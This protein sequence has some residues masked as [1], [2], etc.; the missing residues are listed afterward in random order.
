[1]TFTSTQKEIIDV[2]LKLVDKNKQHPKREDMAKEGYSNNKIRRHFTSL[3]NLRLIVKKEHP[4]KFEDVVDSSL[5]TR[6]KF[7]E[8][9]GEVSKYK[10]FVIT[11]AVND[12][13]I[14]NG[15]LESI[16]QY[17]KINDAILL[18][19][20]SHDPAHN[21]EKE[22]S[23]KFDPLLTKRSIVFDDLELNSNLFISAIKLSAKHI[24][25]IT[26]LERIGQ[27]DGSF[28][29]ASPKQRLK[30]VPTSN[31]KLPHAIMTTGAITTPNYKTKRYLSERT[32]YIADND[33]IL[34]AIIVEVVDKNIFHF[35]QIQADK[36]GSFI[37]LGK[38]YNGSSVKDIKPEA[39]IV[40]DLHSGEVNPDIRKVWFSMID[41]LKP[42]QLV[43]HDIFNGK[44]IN[45]HERERVINRAKT[46]SSLQ[47]EL[48]LTASELNDF[49]KHA[50]KL[51]VVK[52]NHDEFLERYLNSGDW[53]HDP[54][55]FKVATELSLEMMK[56]NNPLKS[57]VQLQLHKPD[58]FVWLKRDD[59]YKIAGVQLGAHGDRG[60]SGTKGSVKTME[61]SYGN[62][63]FGHFHSAEILRNAWCVGTSTFMKLGYNEGPS[64]WTNT[65]CILYSNGSKQLVNVIDGRWRL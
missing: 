13:K 14:N 8:L 10:R 28:I 37:D 18:I 61:L 22:Y 17:C 65:S 12:C 62:C 64:K 27:R 7:Q 43:L 63:I 26:G 31:T 60:P 34:G 41:E 5:F 35:R 40:G 38:E 19:L 39:I 25:P 21:L 11:T 4:E 49:A 24:D 54:V 46:N 58:K 32:A 59:D 45:P 53:V 16:D 1:M 48:L 33:H 2:Y 15:F 3:S 47:Y 23:W 9:K 20:P 57:A 44:S 29:Y 55:N 36:N 6:R 30:Y 51:V 42:K 56:G 52:S 50:E